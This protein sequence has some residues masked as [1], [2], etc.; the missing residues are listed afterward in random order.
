M[1][2][3]ML[4]PTIL[5]FI[6]AFFILLFVPNPSKNGGKQQQIENKETPHAAGKKPNPAPVVSKKISYNFQHS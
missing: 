6:N 5:A 2:Y 4:I 1:M 3:A